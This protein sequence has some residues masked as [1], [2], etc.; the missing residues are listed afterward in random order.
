MP[1]TYLAAIKPMLWVAAHTLVI[2]FFLIFLMRTIGRRTLGQLSVVDLVIIMV[3]G[4][5]VETAMVNGDTSLQAGLVCAFTLLV[6]NRTLAF[7]VVRSRRLRKLVVGNP[8]L[9][10]HNGKFI[11]DH[12]RRAGLTEE[13]VMEALREREENKLDDIL[14]AVLEVDGTINVVPRRA[15]TR[16]TK[17]DVRDIK[18]APDGS[19][20]PISP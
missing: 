15:E 10:V 2:Y 16:R 18:V 8:M 19:A 1:S 9:L 4:S 6:A 17:K 13:D 7:F 5:A 3:M 20:E 12:L 14:F 11:E